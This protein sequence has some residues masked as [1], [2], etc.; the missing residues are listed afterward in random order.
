[1]HITVGRLRCSHAYVTRSTAWLVDVGRQYVVPKWIASKGCQ[2]TDSVTSGSVLLSN[3]C[4]Q[5]G[6]LGD[7]TN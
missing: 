4:P 6:L 3:K 1:M 7:R 5:I 2:F